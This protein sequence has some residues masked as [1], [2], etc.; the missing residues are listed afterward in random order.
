MKE[1]LKKRWR[2][3]VVLVYWYLLVFISSGA[4]PTLCAL[5]P[6]A[7]RLHQNPG[8]QW[9]IALCSFCRRTP[10]SYPSFF[11]S[12]ICLASYPGRRGP[13]FLQTF[14][15]LDPRYHPGFHQH[16][17]QKI[18]RAALPSPSNSSKT[19]FLNRTALRRKVR[20][21]ILSAAVET[22]LQEG[23]NFEFYLNQVPYGGTAYGLESA[24]QTYFGKKP[25]T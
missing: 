10:H 13:G 6:T 24:S 19:P 7:P 14:R 11:S 21:F 16:L 25:P 8:P 4:C 9:Q 17:L 18:S 12:Q 23:P 1:K 22:L 20:E 3:L 5:P 2:L 15:V